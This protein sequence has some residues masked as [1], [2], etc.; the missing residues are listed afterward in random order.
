MF[1]SF[2][3]YEMNWIASVLF[4]GGISLV[5]CV[6]RINSK[7]NIVSLSSPIQQPYTPAGTFSQVSISCVKCGAINPSNYEFCGGCGSK[8]QGED[9]TKI[10]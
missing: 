8:L 1:N 6:K 3:S 2:F 5:F 7:K 10:Y 4:F 9:A